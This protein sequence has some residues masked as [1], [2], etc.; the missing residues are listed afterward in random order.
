ML[1][2]PVDGTVSVLNGAVGEFVAASSGTSALA[3]G[4]GAAIP[5]TEAASTAAGASTVSRPGGT[6]FIV[7][8]GVDTFQV[9]V[10]FEESDAARIAPNQN[11]DVS[12]GAVPD[13]V[14]HGTVLA[15]APAATATS[16]VVGYYVTVLLTETDPR[17][18]D[19]QTADAAVHVDE[20]RDVPAVPNAAVRRS[21]GTTTVTVL[22]YDGTPR[23]VPFQ[24]GVVGDDLTQIVSGLTV[25]DE[26]VVPAG[27]S[28]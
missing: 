12:V 19:G 20:V 14:R 1:R 8:D 24:A 6:Q 2:A 23:T 21:G 15:V 13:L 27:P 4:S 28:A 26:V 5:G 25:G 22:G 11:V 18:R 3:P 17:L 7:L 10:P 9:V 16:G